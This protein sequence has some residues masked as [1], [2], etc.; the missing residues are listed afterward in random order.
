MNEDHV[1][2]AGLRQREDLLA[3]SALLLCPGG[4]FLPDPDDFVAGLLDEGAQVPFLAG[5]GL[6]G[7]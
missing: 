5:T 7:G 2:L 4:G 6:V 1:D 3:F